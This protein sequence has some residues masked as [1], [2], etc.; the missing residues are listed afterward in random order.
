MK[1]ILFRFASVLISLVA[2]ALLSEVALRLFESHDGIIR[3]FDH[4]LGWVPLENVSQ[5][6]VHQ[7]QLGLRGPD[8]MQ[9][10]KTPEES[11][12]LCWVI[13]TFGA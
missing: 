2:V 4:D 8:D 5:Q 9:L 1:A 12:F 7:N 6:G 10:E 3:R 11:E 13:H